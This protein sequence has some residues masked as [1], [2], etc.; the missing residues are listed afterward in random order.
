VSKVH[1]EYTPAQ[2]AELLGRVRAAL[3]EAGY[4]PRFAYGDGTNVWI[5]MEHVPSEVV[6]TAF[7]V[8]IPLAERA[9]HLSC[10]PCWSTSTGED[11]DHDPA[12]QPRPSLKGPQWTSKQPSTC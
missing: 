4:N 3:A 10:W 6:W 12:T 8:C 5:Q 9:E 1:P 7:W 11:C 2:A